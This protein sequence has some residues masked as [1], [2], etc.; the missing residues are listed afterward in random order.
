MMGY[1]VTGLELTENGINNTLAKLE[2]LDLTAKI[3]Q[4]DFHQLPFPKESFEAVISI[5]ALHYN[6]WHGAEKSFNEISRVLKTGGYFF[7]RA[8]SEKG[9]WRPSDEVVP[10]KGITRREYRG[11]E[12]F[13]V[14]VHDYTLSELEELAQKNSLKILEAIDEDCE[15]RPGQWN[16]VFQKL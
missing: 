15:G 4:G 1:N 13:I 8:R 10:D 14:V 3:I 2:A 12:K 16:V 11:P 9:H 6:D 5:Q 7:F